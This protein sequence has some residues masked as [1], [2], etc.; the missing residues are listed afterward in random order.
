MLS[1][2][3]E[4]HDRLADA[5]VAE[6]SQGLS[7]S[8]QCCASM[9]RFVSHPLATISSQLPQPDA[10]SITHSPSLQADASLFGRPAQ[11]LSQ[12]PQCSV[13]LLRSASQPVS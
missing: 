4:L 6:V 2:T 9:S 1:S 11:V 12:R 8:P 13:S 3:A 10:Q 7:Q 5:L